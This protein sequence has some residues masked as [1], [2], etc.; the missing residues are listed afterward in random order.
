MLQFVSNNSEFS[1]LFD[2]PMQNGPTHSVQ[3]TNP[4]TMTTTTS[5]PAA[6]ATPTTHAPIQSIA[7][8]QQS[9]ATPLLQPRPQPQTH[10]QVDPLQ[11]PTCTMLQLRWFCSHAVMMDICSTHFYCLLSGHSLFCSSADSDLS[12]FSHADTDTADTNAD[13]D[14]NSH[15]TTAKIYTKSCHLPPKPQCCLSG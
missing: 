8:S 2:D 13:S 15:C 12:E 6:V 9:R 14:D 1:D 5:A 11:T 3:S 4:I 10:I 7:I